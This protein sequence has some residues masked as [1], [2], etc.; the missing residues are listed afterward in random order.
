MLRRGGLVA[1]PTETVYGLGANAL[2]RSAVAGIFAAKGRPATNPIIVHIANVSEAKTLVSSW[3][4]TA[5]RLADAFWPGSLTLVLAKAE[6]VP[7]LVTAGGDTVAIRCPAHPVA[8]GLIEAAGFPIAAPSAN[9]S[10]RVSPT[11]A[12]HVLRSLDGRIDMVLD[13]GPTSGGV[14]S[15]VLDVTTTP[16]R[17]LRP[18]LVLPHQIE[19][20]IG[21]IDVAL[22]KRSV[23]AARSPGMLDR[24]YA[25]AIPLDCLEDSRARLTELCAAGLRVGWLTIG[26]VPDERSGG[27]FVLELPT[28]A[29]DYASQLYAA[30]HTLEALGLDRIVVELPPD[31]EVWSAVRDRLCRAAAPGG[32][33]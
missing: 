30:L 6:C 13:G 18:G 16:A 23:G 9:A 32:E 3:T 21:P 4:P 24:H 7:D 14:E 8:L 11:R 33:A 15:T 25:P 28:D 2:D 19:Q 5:T 1:F 22:D 12:E 20:V 31:E 29:A 17:L 10:T 26:P 27:M